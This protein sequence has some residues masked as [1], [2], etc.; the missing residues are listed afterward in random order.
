MDFGKIGLV[1]IVAS[2]LIALASCASPTA[3]PQ[4][5]PL[6]I[7]TMPPGALAGHAQSNPTIANAQMIMM[8]AWEFAFSPKQIRVKTGEPI[9]I[10]FVNEGK[11]DHDMKIDAV[12]FHAHAEPNKSVEASF[13]VALKG[14]YEVYCSVSGHKEAGM[15]SK[16]I[17]E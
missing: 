2:A 1:A 17:V 3:T 12:N 5:T 16:L 10:M 4:P 14:E 13:V 7:A 15:V 9:T 11:V 8:D 6:P